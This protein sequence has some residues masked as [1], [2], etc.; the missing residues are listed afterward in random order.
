MGSTKM[1][2][3]VSALK[4]SFNTGIRNRMEF[5]IFLEGDFLFIR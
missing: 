2:Q 5:Y 3:A 4:K 1:L